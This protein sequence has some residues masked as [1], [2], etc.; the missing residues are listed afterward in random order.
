MQVIEGGTSNVFS[1]TGWIN[2]TSTTIAYNW[3]I[4]ATATGTIGAKGAYVNNAR[5][6]VVCGG[7]DYG[8]CGANTPT[9]WNF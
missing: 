1:D 9:G 3:G 6:G 4:C 7:Q 8:V 2:G 5:V